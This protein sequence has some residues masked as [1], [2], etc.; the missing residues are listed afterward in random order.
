MLRILGQLASSV[1]LVFGAE[2]FLGVIF[3]AGF[4]AAFGVSLPTVRIDA[5]TA[6]TSAL[7]PTIYLAPAA[8]VLFGYVFA[9]A[10]GLVRADAP[11]RHTRRPP[12][13]AAGEP[14]ESL[15][16]SGPGLGARIGTWREQY[17]DAPLL[18]GVGYS[19]VVGL[20]AFAILLLTVNLLN[21]PRDPQTLLITAI[22]PEAV[23]L[24]TIFPAH[25]VIADP[26]FDRPTAVW[27]IALATI[28]LTG[29]A[30]VSSYVLGAQV[31]GTHTAELMSPADLG[32][33]ITIRD[34]IPGLTPA[35]PSTPLG[36][37]TYANIVLVFR[38]DQA[39]LFAA[40]NAP[41]E[42]RT[43]LVPAIQVV[44]ISTP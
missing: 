24:L 8:L 2:G 28:V 22:M 13:A 20:V 7:V 14:A 31:A 26:R 25:W 23:A 27:W 40:R 41:G 39:W 18:R 4:L 9:V 19:L 17:L 36:A 6:V 16:G 30:S 10:V 37:T 34:A 38:D 35:G 42:F 44:A 11:D 29:V 32:T 33:T 3:I 1:A 5:L 15:G 21:L 12:V 43:Y